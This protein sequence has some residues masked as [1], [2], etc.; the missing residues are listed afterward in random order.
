[1][2]G[3]GD[4]IADMEMRLHNL[5]RKEAPEEMNEPLSMKQ[6]FHAVRDNLAPSQLFSSF[7]RS[8]INDLQLAYFA[9]LYQEDIRKQ[10]AGEPSSS[11]REDASLAVHM[12]HGPAGL[13]DGQLQHAHGAFIR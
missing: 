3:R 11:D 12:M 1:M 6:A 8:R 5:Q 13:S 7:R 2:K 10:Q 4:V 9:T